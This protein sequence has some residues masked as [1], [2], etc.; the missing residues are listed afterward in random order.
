MGVGY[1]NRGEY[2]DILVL[3]RDSL[4]VPAR[5]RKLQKLNYSAKM[6]D[7]EAFLFLCIALYAIVFLMGGFQGLDFE[8]AA[9]KNEST[10]RRTKKKKKKRIEVIQI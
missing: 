7:Q 10:G 6:D 8:P 9:A 3:N 1:L 2:R 5:R 4:F